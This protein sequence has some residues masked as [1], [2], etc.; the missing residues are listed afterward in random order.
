MAPV[1]RLGDEM[2]RLREALGLS[3]QDVA[4]QMRLRRSSQVSHWETGERRPTADNLKAVAPILKTT[5][6]ALLAFG[7]HYDPAAPRRTKR[8]RAAERANPSDDRKVH[9]HPAGLSPRVPLTPQDS[10]R[11]SEVAV[12]RT[13]TLR[14]WST[15]TR[16]AALVEKHREHEQQLCQAVEAVLQSVEEHGVLGAPKG[17]SRSG[18]SRR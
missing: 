18:G 14:S 9:L 3:Q 8:Q 5:F 2:R 6:A 1:G 13:L 12:L 4:A 10:A 16:F 17:R 11:E 7:E 15:V